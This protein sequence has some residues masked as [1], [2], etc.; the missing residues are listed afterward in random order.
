M[1][2]VPAT[3]S[4]KPAPATTPGRSSAIISAERPSAPSADEGAR[5]RRPSTKAVV[6]QAARVAEVGAPMR[7]T[8][9]HTPAATRAAR[10]RGGWPAAER[11]A[12]RRVAIT[13]TW[14][15]EIERRCAVPDRAKASQSSRGIPSR[16]A[17][18]SADAVPAWVPSL[19]WSASWARP[20]IAERAR[21]V[22]GTPPSPPSTTADA[23]RY[24]VSVPSGRAERI[25]R[26]ST[27]TARASGGAPSRV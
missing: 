12:P 19:R 22:H 25:H 20:R 6:I 13:P 10:R 3:V 8:Y 17:S 18:T 15:P 4:W 2:A 21:V 14:K 26:P 23:L 5:R 7:R 16:S 27:V 11:S 24:T 1:P 9:A